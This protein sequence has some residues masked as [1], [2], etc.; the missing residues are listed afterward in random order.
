MENI[1]SISE[2]KN[3]IQLL[4][5]EQNLKLQLLKE[6]FHITYQSLRPVNLL[7]NTFKEVATSPNLIDN[8]LGTVVGLASGYLSKKNSSGCFRQYSAKAF[9]ICFAIRSN[10]L[11][12]TTS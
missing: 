8:L 7:L 1:T 9:G 10:K 4:E 3:A 2:L 11:G 6:Q 12:C 5:V